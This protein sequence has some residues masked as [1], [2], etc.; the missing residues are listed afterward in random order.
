MTSK[1]KLRTREKKGVKRIRKMGVHYMD[2]GNKDGYNKKLPRVRAMKS[3]NT[4]SHQ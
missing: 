1:I 4:D 3:R 2:G